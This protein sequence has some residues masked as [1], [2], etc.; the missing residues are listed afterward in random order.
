M[1]EAFRDR[2]FCRLFTGRVITNVGDSFYLVA[3]MWLVY[4]LTNDPVYT[5]IA[6]F[7]T[8]TPQVFQFL[9]GPLVDR[10]SIRRTL[11]GTQLIQAV[12]V[13]VIPIAHVFGFLTVEL[14]L[15]VMPVLSALNQL[16]YPAQ[17]T[18]LPRIL[19]REELVA[20]NSAFS[21]A[22]QGFDTV[23]NGVGGVLIGLFSAITLF[24]FDAITFGIAAIVFATVS[25]PSAN[26]VSDDNQSEEPSTLSGDERQAKDSGNSVVTDGDGSYTGAEESDSYLTR[27]RE[28]AGVLRGTPLVPLLAGAVV[29]NFSVGM[30][31]A[32]TPAYADSLVV[33][34]VVSQIGAAGSY[35]ILMGSIAA[36]GFVGA[37]AAN[38]VA[39]RPL[40]RSMIVGYT[41]A[42]LLWSGALLANWL[43]LT[44]LLFALTNIPIGV[45][46]VYVATV[47]QAAPPAEKVGRVSSIYGSASASMIPIGSL[48]GGVFAGWVSPRAAMAALGVAAIALALYVLLNPELRE[49]P[50]PDRVTIE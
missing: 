6:G 34:E 45:V 29:A 11:V 12:V 36:G 49:L 41:V 16:V 9:A 17:S 10:W 31:L 18:A 26:T 2:T 28:G 14:V 7:V 39:T 32:A 3:A 15:I 20:A 47:F 37:L 43:P 4:S 46:S 1:R 22:Y 40:G 19:D 13:S 44:A 42:G 21:V 8:M 27:M 33:P 38:I 24:I 48:A 23:A 30:M 35:G 25:I 50:S 5:G